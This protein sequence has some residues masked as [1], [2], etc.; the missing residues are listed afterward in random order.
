MPEFQTSFMKS[1]PTILNL[2][3]SF[4]FFRNKSENMLFTNIPMSNSEAELR[5]EDISHYSCDSI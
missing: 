5:D 4:F 2:K 1:I 3:K